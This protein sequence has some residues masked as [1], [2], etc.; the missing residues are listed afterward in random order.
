MNIGNCNK[1]NTKEVIE[2]G[3]GEDFICPEC[4]GQLVEVPGRGPVWPYVAGV[5]GAAV[6]AAGI[7]FLP[8]M[9]SGEPVAEGPEKIDDGTTVEVVDGVNPEEGTETA[10]AEETTVDYNDVPA[11]KTPVASVQ[12]GQGTIDF[13]YAKYEGSISG[14]KAN[15]LGTLTYTQSRR[16]SKRDTKDRV[17]APGDYI[18]GS[19]KDNEPV[20]VKWYGAD[21]K[22]KGAVM[23]GSNGL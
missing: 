14:G 15:G 21:K 7:Y 17:A 10:G 1:A 20:T 2:V 4:K 3:L 23:I 9:M 5:V 11:P 18:E 8:G 22:L 19:F 6:V 12:D 16:I 13:G